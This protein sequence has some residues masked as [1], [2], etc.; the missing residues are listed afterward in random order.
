MEHILN[1]TAL[2]A[3]GWY[4]TE[5]KI[6]DLW[7]DLVKTLN[8]DGWC[9]A[10]NRRSVVTNIFAQLDEDPKW[11]GRGY[12]EIGFERFYEEFK[13]TKRIFEMNGEEMDLEIFAIFYFRK[14]LICKYKYCFDDKVEP[15]AE[16][17]PLK[18]KRRLIWI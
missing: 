5:P 15:N 4:K 11:W 18:K 10:N 13:D 6:E 12:G 14:L 3:K 17:L 8:A 2:W 16:V 1:H 7:K 9:V